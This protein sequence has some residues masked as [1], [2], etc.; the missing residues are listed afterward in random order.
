MTLDC[1]RLASEGS[2]AA[3]SGSALCSR[4]YLV[5]F[6]GCGKTRIG[7]LLADAMGRGFL[8]ID[9]MIEEEAGCTVRQIFEQRGEV[10]FRR[11]ETECLRRSGSYH[12]VVV[13]TGGG[14]MASE[15]NRRTLEELG[16]TV[17]LDVPFDV[18][19]G[20][21]SVHGLAKRPL[22]DDPE[23]ARN[24]YAERLDAYRQADL[25]VKVEEGEAASQVAAR[26][27]DLIQPGR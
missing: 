25:H 17:W 22:L 11:L 12:R 26:I 18:I 15:A 4:I 14:V 2:D 13:A 19:V 8:D 1:E 10:E 6:M 20:R 24:L 7:L 27:L 9:R 3:P 16:S 5:G 21:M 23:K